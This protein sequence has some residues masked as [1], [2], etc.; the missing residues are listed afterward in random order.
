MNQGKAMPDVFMI[1]GANG[2]GKTTVALTVLPKYLSV[3]EFVNADEIA[4]GINRVRPETA[5]LA[6]GRTMIER[7]DGLI[8]AGTSFAFETTCAGQ[9]HLKTLQKCKQANYAISL[10]FGAGVAKRA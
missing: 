7:L 9:H 4:R 6:A 2:A 3:Y 10:V 1:G 5:N 8:A